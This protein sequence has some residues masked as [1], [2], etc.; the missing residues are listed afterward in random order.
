[1][2]WLYVQSTGELYRPDGTLAG[3]GYAGCGKGK[4]RPCMDHVRNT[5]PLPVGL[6]RIGRPGLHPKLG[7]IAIPLEPDRWNRMY[8]RG[9]FYVH[10]D[11]AVN[12][13]EASEGCIVAGPKIRTELAQHAGEF[14]RVEPFSPVAPVTI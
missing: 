13:G 12:P 9:G 4:N 10:G 1:M 2:T 8:D 14:L 3:K 11:S 6:Y 5:G 7:P